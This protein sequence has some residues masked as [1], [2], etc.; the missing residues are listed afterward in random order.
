MKPIGAGGKAWRIFDG[1]LI[2]STTPTPTPTVTPT[3]TPAPSTS[4]VSVWETFEPVDFI[5]LPLE[6]DGTYDF[7]VDWGDGTSPDYITSWNQAEVTHPYGFAGRYNVVISGTCIGWSFNEDISRTLKFREV[8]QWGNLGLGNNGHNF[9]G[10]AT[11][12]FT[13]VTDTLNLTSTTNLTNMFFGCANL[14]Y[15]NNMNS[16]NVSNVTDMSYMFQNCLNFNQSLSN[17]NVSNVKNMDGMFYGCDNFNGNI[18]GWTVSGVTDMSNMFSAAYKFNQNIGNWDVKNVTGMTGMFS[19]SPVFNQNISGW[20]VGKVKD[21][22]GMFWSTTV[23][24]QPIGSWN[25]SGVT[26]MSYMFGNATGF[27]QVISGWNVS[28]VSDFTGFMISRTRAQYPSTNYA[29]LLK[30]W[31]QRNVVSGLT[32]DF[33]AIKYDA[34][35]QSYRNILTNPPKNWDISDGGSL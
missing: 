9:A 20:N 2:S 16:W 10:C 17:W 3:P 26:D 6:S 7:I 32:I 14:T 8:K 19:N 4:F 18:S 33:G 24:N 1:G 23:F 35:G 21:M 13:G 28:N 34:F 30:G 31:S 11:T 5:T 25:V 15:V 12:I 22:S 27:T 29:A